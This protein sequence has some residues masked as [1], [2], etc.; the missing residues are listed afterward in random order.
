MNENPDLVE[1]DEEIDVDKALEVLTRHGEA[2][3]WPPNCAENSMHYFARQV[4]SVCDSNQPSMF[5]HAKAEVTVCVVEPKRLQLWFPNAG[6]SWWEIRKGVL[7]KERSR[8]WI[9]VRQKT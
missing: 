3:R 7:H 4:L 6:A 5:R 9:R 2:C 1:R 8:I